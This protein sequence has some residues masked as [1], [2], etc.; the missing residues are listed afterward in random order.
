[1]RID[2][3]SYVTIE[4]VV[5]VTLTFE[6]LAKLALEKMGS[7]HPLL[8]ERRPTLHKVVTDVTEIEGDEDVPHEFP[9]RQDVHLVFRVQDHLELSKVADVQALQALVRRHAGGT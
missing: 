6:E 1:M 7:E 2:T 3:T 8:H 4:T 9:P 5:K